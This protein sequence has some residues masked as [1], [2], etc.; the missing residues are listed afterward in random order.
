MDNSITLE[1]HT[2]SIVSPGYPHSYPIISCTWNI[3]VPDGYILK[4]K[5]EDFELDCIGGNKL[6]VGQDSFCGSSKPSGVLSLERDLKIQM[7]TREAKD[8]RG[9]RATFSMKEQGWC[10]FNKLYSIRCLFLSTVKSSGEDHG[11]LEI[12]LFIMCGPVSAIPCLVTLKFPSRVR[13]I[14]HE[15]NSP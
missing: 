11:V 1:S 15:D 13:I 8:N 3:K 9:F 2:G 10:M 14:D 6:V 5:V 12:K 4:V 7:I